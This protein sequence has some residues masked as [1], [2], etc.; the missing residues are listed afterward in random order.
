[1]RYCP[2]LPS[3]LCIRTLEH[4]SL[5]F[6]GHVLPFTCLA[7]KPYVAAWNIILMYE[8]SLEIPFISL[9]STQFHIH[10]LT[11][12]SCT[13]LTPKLRTFIPSQN[14]PPWICFKVADTF[15]IFSE[16]W[17]ISRLTTAICAIYNNGKSYPCT[18]PWRPIG[19]WNVEGPTVSRQS[20]HR[21]R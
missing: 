15:L 18:G 1:M 6:E 16:A 20:A 17:R 12:L 19:L 4:E 10:Y 13:N 9:G 2:S 21:W 3:K 5:G 11:Y 14:F 7:R 8:S